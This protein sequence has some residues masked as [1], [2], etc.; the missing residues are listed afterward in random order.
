MDN[1]ELTLGQKSGFISKFL[2]FF[3]RIFKFTPALPETQTLNDKVT[4]TDVFENSESVNNNVDELNVKSN[5]ESLELLKLQEKFESNQI[6]LTDLSD[7]EITNLNHL[8]QRQID[9]LK[10]QLSFIA[11]N[12]S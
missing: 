3:K 4:N 6:K 5:E 12:K 7:D 9:D 11:E 2:N 8:Y 10:L 1:N